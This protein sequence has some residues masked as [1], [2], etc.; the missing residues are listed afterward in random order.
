MRG[1]NAGFSVLLLRLRVRLGI[2]IIIIIIMVIM[3]WQCD[4]DAAFSYRG[5]RIFNLK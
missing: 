2:T 3:H 1:D 4:D 5:R